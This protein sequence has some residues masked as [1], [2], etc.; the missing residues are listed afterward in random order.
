[1][2]SSTRHEPKSHTLY[3]HSLFKLLNITIVPK[4]MRSA[5][6]LA[7]LAASVMA[8]SSSCP[9]TTTITSSATS[10]STVYVSVTALD[11]DPLPTVTETPTSYVITG[12]ETVTWPVY[13]ETCTSTTRY[14]R[15]TIQL[16]Q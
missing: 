6:A 7:G 9:L 1:M 10:K 16:I 13:E 11:S 5:I 12:T 15:V 14:V 8:E 2:S 3:T 4:M